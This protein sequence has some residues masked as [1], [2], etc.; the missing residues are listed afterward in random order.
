MDARKI[1]PQKFKDM[2]RWRPWTER[3]FRVARGSGC[4]S[5]SP[6]THDCAEE[7]IY[8]WPH[9]EDWVEDSEAAGI[10]KLVRDDDGVEAFRQLNN[11]FGIPRSRS[12]A[13]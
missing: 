6:I 13:G 3:V 9:L 4:C 1:Y 8:Y 5:Q 2:W 12:C 11:M 7:S 10:V